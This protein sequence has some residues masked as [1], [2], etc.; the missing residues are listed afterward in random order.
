MFE[1]NREKLPIDGNALI[2]QSGGPTAAINATL[3]GVIKGLRNCSN[4]KRIYGAKNGI[5]GD[6]EGRI[7]DL[8][9]AVSSA[10]DHYALEC[11]PAAALGS[12]RKKL[13]SDLNDP[14]YAE[15]FNVFR[16]YGIRFF[17][18]IGGNDSMDTA[19]KLSR[20][21]Q[22]SFYE[23]YIVGVPKTI[24]NDIV[25]TDHT[26]GYP[27]ALKYIATTVEEIAR[28]CSIYT[29][30][31]V[32]IVEIMGRDA[33]WLAA[34]AAL[35]RIFG[36][37]SADLVYVAE[38]LFDFDRFIDDVNAVLAKKPNVVVAVSEGIKTAD[39]KY[40]G[41]SAQSGSVDI[42]GH[43]YLAGAAK[44]LETHVRA[45]IGCKCRSIELSLPQRCAGH[46]LSKTDIEESVLVGACCAEHV[47]AGNSGDF[48][49]F[50]RDNNPDG[51]YSVSVG[52]CSVSKV[53][54]HIKTIPVHYI[55]PR[56]N[57]VTDSLLHM[58][59]PLIEGEVAIPTEH[60]LPRHFTID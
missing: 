23:I 52:F 24:D 34:G 35:P 4:V 44:V 2:G 3:S 43:K 54:N 27:S 39:G 19:D 21:A 29:V 7:V 45:K 51:S 20:Y 14:V 59:A 40:V 38:S 46:C 55:E 6:C 36:Q 25:I 17:I 11:T 28:D 22:K 13:P 1:E 16:L 26:P 9:L 58:L 42:F 8:D 47:A 33:G 50:E 31:A 32:T 56:G 48:A 60:G 5:E 18:Y 30:K 57:N 53:A 12:C 15:I 49:Y 41:E 37:A 10:E